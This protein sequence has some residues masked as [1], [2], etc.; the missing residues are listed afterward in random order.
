MKISYCIPSKN[1]LRYL[2]NSIRS[3]LTYGE[4]PEIIVYIDADNDKTEQWLS[5][6]YA[7]KNNIKWIKNDSDIPRGI[8]YGYNR[9]IEIATSD[10]VCMFHADMFMGEGFEKNILKHMTSNSVVS[11]TRIEPPLH[12]PGPEKIVKDFGMYPEDFQEK[13]FNEFVKENIKNMSG[14][15]TRGIFAPWICYKKF[16]SD[17]GM[18]DEIFHS[19]HEDTDIFQRFI[20][21]G[22]NIVQSRDSFVYHLTCRGGQFQDG[23]EKITD[24]KKFH[25]MKHQS[26]NNFIRKW[27]HFIQ[28]DEYYY[29]IISP[30]YD[31]GFVIKNCSNKEFVYLLEPWCDNMFI[32]CSDSIIKGIIDDLQSKSNF[33]LSNKIKSLTDVP[34]NEIIIEFDAEKFQQHH[35]E[36]I[37]NIGL[38]IKNSGEIGEMEYNI[39]KLKI[40]NLNDYSKNLINT[41]DTWYL[42]KLI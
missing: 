35:L 27:G 26:F 31:V 5:N 3:I 11:A 12:P 41:N 13:N 2:K 17:I 29:P 9:C 39:F 16:I 1:N 14:K 23:I 15:T 32:G 20:I 34:R 36:F 18:H 24:D 38:I 10:I 30:R 42:N 21:N 7:T 33:N 40:N 19:Y 22:A 8:A 4:N 6:T 25:E 37:K 28:N